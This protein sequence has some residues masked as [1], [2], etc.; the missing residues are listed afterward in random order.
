MQ[1]TNSVATK[2]E[3]DR[4]VEEVHERLV[5]MIH[6]GELVPD[7]RL[8]QVNLAEQ[9]G[10]SRTP[11]REALLRL[12]QEG[13][14]Y[15]IPRHGMF[16]RPLSGDD[17]RQIYELR[18]LLEPWAARM[19]CLRAGDRERAAVDAIQTKHERRLPTF[20]SNRDFHLRIVE[21]CGNDHA[22]RLLRTLWAQES[23]HRIYSIYGH[24][25][26][27]LEGMVHEHREIVDAFLSGTADKVERLVREHIREARMVTEGAIERTPTQAEPG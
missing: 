15:T 8:H 7:A 26:A 1:Y 21:A 14:V 12:E 13:L 4:L 18:E 23:S 17:V 19:A 16:V 25:P 6:S 27:A 20:D 2:R 22:L 10:V 5:A 11:V 9:F 24:Q 3:P